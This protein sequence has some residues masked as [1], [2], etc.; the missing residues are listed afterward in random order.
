[1]GRARRTFWA[2]AA[3][4]PQTLAVMRTRAEPL[5]IDLRVALPAEWQLDAANLAGVLLSYPATDGTVADHR[6]LIERVHAAQGAV[7]MATDLLALT[8]LTPPG[9]LGADIAIGSSQ[10]FGVPMGF[11]GPH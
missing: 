8:L 5:G 6:A 11:G 9:E 7:V 10:R 2:D 1:I 3:T 4:H